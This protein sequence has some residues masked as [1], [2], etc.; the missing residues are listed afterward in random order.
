MKIL[1]VKLANLNSLRGSH[2]VDFGRD[3]LAGAGRFAITGPT[4]AGK[5]TLLDAITLAL[6][7]KAARYGATPSPED[8]MSRHSGDCMAEV[9]FQVPRGTFRAE[10]QLHRARG[11][12]DAKVQAPKRFVY[13]SSNQPLTQNVRDT[14][15]LIEQLIG[16]DYP[17]FLRSALLA[18]GEFAQFL[19]A[20]P[21]ERAELLESLTG[22]SIYSA[23]GTLAHT[24][25]VRRENDLNARETAIQHIQ[26]LPDE[27]R[28]KL[29]QDK[30]PISLLLLSRRRTRLRINGP[31]W[32]ST[33]PRKRTS[34]FSPAIG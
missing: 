33:R 21:D 9:E 30:R 15:E 26:L 12:A 18:Q 17:R 25:A 8:M 7:G 28:Q 27:Q 10:W 2:E 29:I 20:R 3:P 31:S 5:S 13:D 19:K 16:L 1:R 34:N 11:K 22:T 24:E 32:R 23:L 6:N 4:G 14:E